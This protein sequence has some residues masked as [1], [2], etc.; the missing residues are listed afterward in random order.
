MII[1]SREQM[2][3]DK[4]EAKKT[5][6]SIE[7]DEELWKEFSILVIQKEGYRKKNEVIEKLVKGYVVKNKGDVEAKKE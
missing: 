5:K 3:K 2:K 4:K 1:V 6:T 7:I